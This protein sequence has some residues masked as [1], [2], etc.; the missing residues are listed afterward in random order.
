MRSRNCVQ[1]QVA[2]LLL[3]LAA[4]SKQL[5]PDARNALPPV[6]E[7]VRVRNVRG[8]LT[9][10]VAPI[11]A[12]RRQGY[13]HAARGQAPPARQGGSE[14]RGVPEDAGFGS[15]TA[16]VQKQRAREAELKERMRA[17]KLAEAEKAK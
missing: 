4:I 9:A 16:L 10:A 17:K 3:D 6:L 7:K 13:A 15:V 1:S 11:C 8:A 14:E 12:K 2:Q 5:P